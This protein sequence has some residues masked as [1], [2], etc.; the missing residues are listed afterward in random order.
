MPHTRSVQSHKMSFYPQMNYIIN[1]EKSGLWIK[2]KLQ[3]HSTETGLILQKSY[4][5]FCFFELSRLPYSLLSL[6]LCFLT[7]G[8]IINMHVYLFIRCEDE[9]REGK[10]CHW[11]L[12]FINNWCC[13][14]LLK[15][16]WVS[17]SCLDSEP[18]VPLNLTHT[19]LQNQL[20]HWLYR[21]FGIRS[22][23]L[24]A[25]EQWSQTFIVRLTHTGLSDELCSPSWFF[26]F[27]FVK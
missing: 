4:M 18:N 1:F 11:A 6:L 17:L 12:Y 21:T 22:F 14:R 7:R 24:Y 27:F 9:R 19:A 8:E 15:N 25:I 3:L 5:F 26:F 16:A 20:L 10:L 2:R 23:L 13:D